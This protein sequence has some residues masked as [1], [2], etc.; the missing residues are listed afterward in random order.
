MLGLRYKSVNFGAGKSPGS[1]NWYSTIARGGRSPR[2]RPAI[3]CVGHQMYVYPSFCEVFRRSA[4]LTFLNNATLHQVISSF[5]A[6]SEPVVSSYTRQILQ[7]LDYLH[8]HCIVH[9]GASHPQHF[10]VTKPPG[11]PPQW[12]FRCVMSTRNLTFSLFIVH[13]TLKPKP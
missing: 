2:Y 13:P 6:L 7:G 4:Q 11:L 9:R 12:W 8:K 1:P 10:R 3:S 5:G